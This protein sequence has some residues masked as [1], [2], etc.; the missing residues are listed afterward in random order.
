MSDRIA[1]LLPDT[2][3]AIATPPGAG[4]LGI[5][6]LSGPAAAAIARQLLPGCE[7]RAWQLRHAWWRETDDGLRD[8]VLVG[9]F[10][11]PHSYTAEDVVE[12]SAHGAPVILRQLL[13]AC[14]ERGARLAEPG[15]FTRRAFLH[16]R[17][18]LVQ[19]EAVRDL[20]QAQTLAQARNAA[21]QMEGSLSRRLQPAK[22][23]LKDLIARLE[24]AIDFA[25]DEVL[26]PPADAILKPLAQL[27]PEFERLAA[28]YQEG[29]LLAQGALLAIVGR[30]NAGK[31]SLFNAL[32]RRDR[33]LVSPLPGTTRDVITETLDVGGIPVTLADTA[34]L[35][36]EGESVELM[37]MAKSREA[38]AEANLV[39]AVF[40]RSQPLEASDSE[41]VE[42]L[43]NL[44]R[45]C[46][47]A[48]KCDLPAAWTQH[49]L[50]MP[51]LPVSALTGSGLE[52]LEAGLGRQLLPQ[53]G[54]H[55]QWITHQRQA[56][57]LEAAA[58]ALARAEAGARAGVAH[59]A[60]LIDLYA[61]LHELDALTGQTTIEDILN[62]IFSTFCIGK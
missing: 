31:S 10:P 19:A 12:I 11:A 41:L 25:E 35:R 40:D 43:R 4:G 17:L 2:I 62:L 20:I 26:P 5:V 6:R 38:M 32:L 27:R 44:P 8:E 54:D 45:V 60:L 48:N 52:A 49:Q 59:E 18:D 57:H 24:A 9:F 51:A 16:G 61:G 13:A 34:G 15:E 39:L 42:R 14:L 23:Q 28:S 36:A 1:P 3:A 58:A 37:G 21:L 55:Q 7:L 29:K 56:Q 33:A 30:P 53:G 47:V 46:A 50:G 22:L